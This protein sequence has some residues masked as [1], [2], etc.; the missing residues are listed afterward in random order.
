MGVQVARMRGLAKKKL[1]SC[2]ASPDWLMVED[3]SRR[4]LSSVHLGLM[5]QVALP[6]S[7]PRV[8]S[9]LTEAEGRG[10][11]TPPTV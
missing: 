7:S 1:F 2:E 5:R 3:S 11:A 6:N 10:T 4:P 9:T 8:S